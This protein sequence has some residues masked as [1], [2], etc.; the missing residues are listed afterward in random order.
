MVI[1]IQKMEINMP[2]TIINLEMM[3]ILNKNFI[4]KGK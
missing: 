1:N 2:M 4:L 3:S